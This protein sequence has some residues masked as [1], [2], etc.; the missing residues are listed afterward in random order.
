MAKKHI[1][2]KSAS[3][4]IAKKQ[5]ISKDRADAILAAASRRNA[6]TSSNKNLRKVK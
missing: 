2:F 4:S 1:G 3:A 6:H 5:N